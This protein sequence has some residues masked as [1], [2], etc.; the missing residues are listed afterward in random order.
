MSNSCAL[1]S[2]VLLIGLT[3]PLM[4]IVILIAWLGGVK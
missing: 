3:F 1:I 4:L 2:I